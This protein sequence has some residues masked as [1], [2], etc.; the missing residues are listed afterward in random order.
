M[1]SNSQTSRV[2]GK[3]VKIGRGP[4]AA[5]LLALAAV[6]TWFGV[7]LVSEEPHAGMCAQDT[8][9][10]VNT[11]ES[12]TQTGATLNTLFLASPF[13]ADADERGYKT[14]TSATL[15][16]TVS[17]NANPTNA[18]FD[19]SIVKEDAGT[20]SGLPIFTNLTGTGTF[21]KTMTGTII[22]PDKGLACNTTGRITASTDLEA[23]GVFINS[24]VLN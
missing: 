8:C 15:I 16:L 11:A 20:G 1:V 4:V 24:S 3:A 10:A 17:I 19:C 12:E 13:D 7:N 6:G 23:Y 5:G 21:V 18:S 14:A 2:P 22:A 9:M